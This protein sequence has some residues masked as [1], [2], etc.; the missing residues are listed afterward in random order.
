MELKACNNPSLHYCL[1]QR[2]GKSRVNCP[3]E[4]CCIQL[5]CFTHLIKQQ[6]KGEQCRRRVALVTSVCSFSG[7]HRDWLDE[8]TR[9]SASVA[10]SWWQGRWGKK[11]TTTRKFHGMLGYETVLPRVRGMCTTGVGRKSQRRAKPSR[12][13]DKN[14]LNGSKI[15][16]I[17]FGLQVHLKHIHAVSP[18]NGFQQVKPGAVTTCSAAQK[19]DWVRETAVD[20]PRDF[21]A[22]YR[23]FRGKDVVSRHPSLAPLVNNQTEVYSN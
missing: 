9:H 3:E 10:S 15:Q 19:T 14:S 4:Y 11:V 22:I 16:T 23:K 7:W 5:Q 8:L 6:F 1:L 17:K 18:S 2:P 20:T 21:Q 13:W 12:L